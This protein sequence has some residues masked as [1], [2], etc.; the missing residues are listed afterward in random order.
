VLKKE[1]V[2][3]P[4]IPKKEVHGVLRYHPIKSE[5]QADR[6]YRDK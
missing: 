5:G 4:L 3:V 2:N 1:T 6:D